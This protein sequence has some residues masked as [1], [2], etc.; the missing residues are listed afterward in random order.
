MIVLQA[1]VVSLPLIAASQVTLFTRFMHV[2]RTVRR[3]TRVK[4]RVGDTGTLLCVV[5]FG[6][7]VASRK[8]CPPR[9]TNLFSK[10]ASELP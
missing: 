2:R 4:R 6:G 1:R 8:L 7:H 5:T 3:L 9:S 10:G